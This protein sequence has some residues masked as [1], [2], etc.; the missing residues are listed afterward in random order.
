M[1]EDQKEA[2]KDT[3]CGLNVRLKCNPATVPSEKSGVR[4]VKVYLEQIYPRY[5]II[6][7]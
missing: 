1:A 6:S 4:T 7:Q 2:Y 3:H 5:Q